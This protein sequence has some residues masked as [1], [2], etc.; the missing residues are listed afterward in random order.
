[1]GNGVRR[2]KPG[3]VAAAFVAPGNGDI[4]IRYAPEKVIAAFK[5]HR[6]GNGFRIRNLNVIK[7]HLK[8]EGGFEPHV[9]VQG[10]C[11]M[12]HVQC[13]GGRLNIFQGFFCSIAIAQKSCDGKLAFKASTFD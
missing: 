6:L 12:A 13:A 11:H 2:K 5:F 4:G 3:T 7:D 9:L 10:T 8:L 1:M